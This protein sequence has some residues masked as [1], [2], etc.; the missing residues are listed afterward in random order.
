MK[1]IRKYYEI[2]IDNLL[3][4]IRSQCYFNKKELSGITEYLN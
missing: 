3:L 2:K 4:K 1:L